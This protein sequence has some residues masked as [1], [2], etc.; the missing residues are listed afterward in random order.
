MIDFDRRS[1]LKGFVSSAAYVALR[2]NAKAQQKS[3]PA[4][5]V[6]WDM[7]KAYRES[8]PTRERIC[9]N[10]LWRWQPAGSGADVVPAGEWGHLR[11]PEAWPDGNHEWTEP[12]LYFPNPSWEKTEA[13][14]ETSAW[15]EREIAVPQ[16]WTDRRITLCAGYL[17]SYAVVYLDGVKVG[18]MRFPGGELDLT[19]HCRPG[20]KQ[21]LSMLVAA[22]P[23]KA[24]M[25]SYSDSAA[26]R[27]V[28][29]SVE[30]RGLCGDVYL[31]GEP[32]GARIAD[33]KVETSVRSWE[34]T[35]D[36]AIAALDPERT[37]LVRARI[38]DS[39]GNEAAK[40][41]T[42]QPF[43]PDELSSGRIRIT[44]NWRPEK[45]WD[46][47]TPQNQFDVSVS[48]LDS[49]GKV[50]DQAL[51]VRFGFR[52][53]WI[54]GRDFYLNGTRLYLA[55]IPLDN[56]QGSAT[57]A[58]YEATRATLQRYKSFGINFV[59]THNYGCEPGTHLAF[60]EVLR[61]ADDEGVLVAF[62]QPH[63]G[64][65]TWDKPDADET[66]GYA[67]HA[68]F[69]VRVAQNH[70]SVV[71]YST[72]HNGTGYGE[73]MNPDMIDGLVAPRE[74]WSLI[75]AGRALR[76]EAILRRL[77]PS[78]IVYHHAGNLGS[79]HA[80]NFYGNWI[81]PQEMSD[82]FEHWATVGVKPV[83]PC[84]YSVPL[85]WDWGMYRGWYK[86]KRA[87]GDAVAPWEFCMAE[88]NAQTLGARAYQI[89]E[90]E[91]ENLRWEAEQFRLGRVWKRWDC[92]HTFGSPEFEDVFRVL[93]AQLAE[94]YRAMRTW[95]TATSSPWDTQQ[96]W[97]QSTRARDSGNLKLEMDWEHLQ[98]PGPRPAYVHEDEARELLSYR[99]ADYKP[100][101]V[102]EM[103]YRNC[104]PLLAYI[105]GKPAAFTSKDHNFVT[106]ETAEKQ[107]IL[108]N[109][110]R[111]EV[112]ANC[113]W[114]FDIPQPMSGASTVIV[115]PGNQKRLPL[116][117][118]L[119]AGLAPGQYS[120]QTKVDFGNGEEQKDTFAIDVLPRP[121]IPQ[122][123]GRIALFDPKGETGKLL[124]G[125][126]VHWEPVD[127]SVNVSEYEVLIIGKGALNLQNAAPSLSAVRDGLKVIIFEQTG[128]VLEK[129]FGFR[130]AEYGLRWVFKRVPDHPV[131]SGI[132][133]DHLRNWRG[134]STTLPPRLSYELSPQFS[135]SPA[136][137]WAGIEVTR[138][139]R[140]GNRGNVA[141]A[142]IEKPACGDF[143]PILDG[144][145]ALQY[146]SLLK[147]RAGEGMVLFCQTDISGRTETDPAAET[148]AQ[149]IVEYVEAWK[150]GPMRTVV[151]AGDDA[152][153]SYL[154]AAGFRPA[155]YDGADLAAAQVLVVAP[156]GGK[157]LAA[158]SADIREW[159]KAGGHMLA[160]GLDAAEANSFLPINVATVRREHIAACFEPFS[161]SSP[162]A[163][164]S[165][166]EVHNRDPRELDLISG[167][168][169]AVGDGVLATAAN[170]RVVFCQLV[171]WQFDYS[172]GKMNI[173]RT[174]RR[175]ACLLAR[176]LGNLQAA[177][178]T[179][180]LEHIAT[181]VAENEKRWIENEKR[182][183]RGLYLD[184]P[185]EWDDPYRFFRW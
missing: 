145:Y 6:L 91:K 127:A 14:N 180:I 140:C 28:A 185:E 73:D 121:A 18:E 147:H 151:Y 119:P 65:Y 171:P 139:W 112:T 131:L 15:Y 96:Y 53:F 111:V 129:R 66:N 84:E 21:I 99:P 172:G 162:L 136:V 3:P 132:A 167:G 135:G 69:Y 67:Q 164:V 165:P 115:P 156:G 2:P 93:A 71:C 36:L 61:A 33:V 184:T 43:Q 102:A 118:E 40:E 105:G 101:P 160:L 85:L 4:D 103:M 24:V 25:M 95:G 86:G 13:S 117:L 74:K 94:N 150:P 59:Y 68:E 92:P 154:D 174:Y 32:S 142:L 155:V 176:L 179:P 161:A 11:V 106:G 110:S 56:A 141:S 116:K 173:K 104:M 75:N 78:R 8:T 87:F 130:I 9:V 107:L 149:N 148:L 158:R 157:K 42:S 52:E 137:K 125:M 159:L 63:F 146:S 126:D 7:A 120:L 41:F 1:F 20:Q 31:V 82:W 109:N 177:G 77:D 81:P 163:G 39:D 122:A 49:A 97:I 175:A 19:G 44:E 12:Q 113:E 10:G 166:A 100:T 30:R 123:G 45:L 88:W 70:P 22:M 169:T 50:L 134:D 79:M 183:S 98:R 37:Y 90:A 178:E 27:Q 168:A 58:S 153:K 60:E 55:A 38:V 29:G 108:I 124:D 51:P 76:A 170:G 62:S 34:I 57:M 80:I 89:T 182:G 143:L 46:T 144:G 64:Q 133:D 181:P 54:D 128:E 35:F 152:G 23:L 138:V 5:D 83:F 48:L 16:D 47:H 114:S 72:S 26:A 17:N